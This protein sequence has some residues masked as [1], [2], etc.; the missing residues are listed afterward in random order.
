[1]ETSEY[2]LS[3]HSIAWVM[4]LDE[5]VEGVKEFAGLVEPLDL[6]HQ[7]DRKRVSSEH[8]CIIN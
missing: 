5:K 4:T 6:H 7:P 3:C 1:M 8:C 2:H